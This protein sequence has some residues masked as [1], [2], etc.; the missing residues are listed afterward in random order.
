MKLLSNMEHINN[1]D[2][3][4]SKMLELEMKTVLDA[5]SK[6]KN[7]DKKH[8]LIHDFALRLSVCYTD[9]SY[10]KENHYRHLNDMKMTLA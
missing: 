3:F 4:C 5:Y 7:L 10:L 2:E 8:L 9:E 6:E 1:Y